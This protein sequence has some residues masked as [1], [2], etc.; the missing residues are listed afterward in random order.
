MKVIFLDYD[1]V[2]NNIMWDAEGKRASY[3]RPDQIKVNDFQACQ[4]VSEFC[5]KYNYSIV[6]TSTWRFNPNYKEALYNGGLRKSIEILGK[7]GVDRGD[8][9]RS[10]LIYDYLDNHPEITGY[11]I[12]DD[13]SDDDTPTDHL[14]L[15]THNGFN[16]TDFV[17][18]IKLH[19]KLGYE[20][21]K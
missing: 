6:V 20:C 9:K 4:W 16:Y 18:A 10:Q 11:L 7:V 3:G 15:C 17:S 13:E 21:A 2:V 1:G 8:T 14:V 12:F 19:E 5:E